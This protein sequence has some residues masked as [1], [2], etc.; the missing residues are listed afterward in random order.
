MKKRCLSG[1]TRECEDVSMSGEND[2]NIIKIVRVWWSE[3]VNEWKFEM[4]K[5]L[6]QD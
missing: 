1:R 3:D 2:L 6:F 5:F 4:R